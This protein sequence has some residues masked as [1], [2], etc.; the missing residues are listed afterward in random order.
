M[1][2]E[3][4]RR[5]HGGSFFHLIF[6]KSEGGPVQASAGIFA[7]EFNR[8]NSD[9]NSDILYL[10]LFKLLLNSTVDHSFF[11]KSQTLLSAGG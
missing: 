3:V 5:V 9:S 6:P 11:W 1:T 2:G 8:Y 7:I 10:Y 4:K